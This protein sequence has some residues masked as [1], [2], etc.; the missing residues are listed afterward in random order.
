M[1]L[2]ITEL[3][4][5]VANPFKAILEE[6][7]S[8]IGYLNGLTYHVD[9]I[10]KQDLLR[11][12]QTSENNNTDIGY[13][14]GANLVI[15]DLSGITDRGWKYHFPTN[16]RYLVTIENLEGQY[17]KMI[18]RE[19][20]YALAQSYEAFISFLKRC[21]AM[22]LE[23]KPESAVSLSKKLDQ[24]LNQSA[25][26]WLKTFKSNEIRVKD[27]DFFDFIKKINS[28]LNKFISPKNIVSYKIYFDTFAEFR[29]IFIHSLG[30]FNLED[31]WIKRWNTYKKT[32]LKE[33]F[34]YKE[35]N[36]YCEFAISQQVSKENLKTLSELAF[37][38][39]KHLSITHEF[40]W[41]IFVGMP[42]SESAS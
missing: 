39:F 26:E 11:I 19:C 3:E 17:A 20:G 12:K 37:Q 23:L 42:K 18:E 2:K 30:K 28:D 27:A 35:G 6:L 38:I 7:F 31:P 16:G 25:T 14:I 1:S 29:H 33:L 24:L 21:S 41:E 8:V 36:E 5:N 4:G 13:L 10:L 34:P 40:E 22:Q 9:G 32:C 15:S